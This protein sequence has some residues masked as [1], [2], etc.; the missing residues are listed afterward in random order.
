MADKDLSRDSFPLLRLT[1]EIVNGKAGVKHIGYFSCRASVT[2]Y[3]AM[4][5]LITQIGDPLIS[6]RR[7]ASKRTDTLVDGTQLTTSAIDKQQG[8]STTQI[9]SEASQVLQ[10]QGSKGSKTVKLKATKLIKDDVPGKYHQVSFR[11]PGWAT[12]LI[13]SNALGLILPSGT[14]AQPIKDGKVFP[15][16]VSPGGKRYPIAT[17]LGA[18]AAAVAAVATDA[19]KLKTL[20]SE[21]GIT[22]VESEPGQV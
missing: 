21:S 18:D 15:Y 19:T 17:K 7:A 16:F 2:R 9:E 5:E 20:I 3:L 1:G 4:E 12:N 11:F 10:S 22:G 6:L 14:I 8:G 13:I